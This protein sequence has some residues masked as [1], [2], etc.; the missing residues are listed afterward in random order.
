MK[1][2]VKQ[3]IN[4]LETIKDPEKIQVNVV[5]DTDEG[6]YPTPREVEL[7]LSEE[8]NFDFFQ[9]ENGEGELTLGAT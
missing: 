5:V 8:K 2:N 6:Y 9:L 3:L 4:Y 1:T 7:D